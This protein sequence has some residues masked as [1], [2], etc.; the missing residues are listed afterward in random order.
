VL[1]QVLLEHQVRGNHQSGPPRSKASSCP[2]WAH[3]MPTV[4]T[5]SASGTSTSVNTTS[6]SGAVEE[7]MDSPRRPAR[8]S[9]ASAQ[10]GVAV[11][12]V[13]GGRG[14]HQSCSC[15]PVV[16]LGAVDGHPSRRA[17]VTTDAGRCPGQTRS[18]RCRASS[19][20]D[21]SRSAPCSGFRPWRSGAALAVGDPVVAPQKRPLRSN[22]WPR[23]T[24]RQRNG[25]AATRGSDIH[26][27]AWPAP[28]KA[29]SLPSHAQAGFERPAAASSPGT[30]GPRPGAGSTSLSSVVELQDRSRYRPTS[31]ADSAQ[32]ASRWSS[33]EAHVGE[34]V[35][36]SRDAS[37]CG[38][39]ERASRARCR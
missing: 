7:G 18:S 20:A 1:A 24:A 36:R 14:D 19:L 33:G 30:C 32:D 4:P 11:L 17:R 37:G 35:E 8:R 21:A 39:S 28:A 16:D 15:A 38:Q 34:V 25:R 22:S 9:S 27:P 31:R 26:P 2:I 12:G 13:A 23:R 29:E 5:T 6:L 3:P 10:P